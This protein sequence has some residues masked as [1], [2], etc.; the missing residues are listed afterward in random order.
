MY[1]ALLQRQLGISRGGRR[2]HV[3]KVQTLRFLSSVYRSRL[4]HRRLGLY[5]KHTISRWVECNNVVKVLAQL[6]AQLHDLI[7]MTPPG[8]KEGRSRD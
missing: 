7:K 6:A 8:R 2:I 1:T 4:Y 5:S 3:S